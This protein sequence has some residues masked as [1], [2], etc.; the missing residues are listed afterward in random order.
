MDGLAGTD[1]ERRLVAD[2]ALVSPDG[3]GLLDAALAAVGASRP[4][5]PSARGL[6]ATG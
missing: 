1:L 5:N 2:L 4:E 6:R 3:I